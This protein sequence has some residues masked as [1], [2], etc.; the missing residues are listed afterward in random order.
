MRA[1]QGDGV[2]GPEPFDGRQV[3]LETPPAFLLGRAEGLQL[4]VAIT[5]A[6]AENQLAVGHD[7]ERAELFR[8]V[9]RLVQ[10]QQQDAGVDANTGRFGGDPREERNLRQ[11][12]Q[13]ARAV[14][15][16]LGDRVVA[17]PLDEPR[18]LQHFREAVGDIV[19]LGELPPHHESELHPAL[20]VF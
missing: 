17:Q 3:F 4:H 20:P 14:M 9:E 11:V 18:L 7:I 2:F 13:R 1:L 15:R 8:H 16:A 5:N 12:L 10:R 6:A 19:A